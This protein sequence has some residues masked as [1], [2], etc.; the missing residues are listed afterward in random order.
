MSAAASKAVSRSAA[1]AM[2]GEWN[3]Q[4]T[5]SRLN[6][7]PAAPNASSPAVNASSE[8]A[9]TVWSGALRFANTRPSTPSSA[10]AT[11]AASAK[12]AAIAPGAS[13]AVAATAAPRPA[14]SAIRVAKSIAPAA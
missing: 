9:M 1:G 6:L 8:P 12:T 5:G 13:L 11:A 4:S 7:S 14:D 10:A 3:A 2:S